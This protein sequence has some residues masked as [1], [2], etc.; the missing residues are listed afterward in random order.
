M[1]FDVVV[2]N[3][4]YLS[5]ED[6]RKANT[7]EFIYYKS[8][9]HS[10]FRQFDKY[11]V[12]IERALSALTPTGAAG[13]LVPN[14]WLT[15]ESASKLRDLLKNYVSEVVDFG[16]ETLFAGRSAYVCMLVLQHNQ[17]SVSYRN[18][19]RQEE[20]EQAPEHKGF[21]MQRAKLLAF[22]CDSWVLPGTVEEDD[23][24]ESIHI[25]SIQLGNL[26]DIRNGIQT[27]KN[28]IFVIKNFSQS[29]G[30]ITFTKN[31]VTWRIES[32]ITRPYVDDSSGVSTFSLTLG[33]ARVVFPYTTAVGQPPAVMSPTDLQTVFPLAWAYLNH[34]KS[35]LEGR[36]VSPPPSAGV[37]YA[38]GRHQALET[39]FIKPKI[40]YSVNQRGD[41]YGF[42][43]AGVAVASGGTA[44]E[45]MILNPK[46]G[47]ALEF[48]LGL[49]N[50][51]PIEFFLRKRGSAFR[52]GYYSRG[53]AVMSKV[54]VPELDLEGNPA[55]IAAHAAIVSNVKAIMAA[56]ALVPTVS[57]RQLIR[58]QR[59]R[60]F[61]SQNLAA[62]FNRL[63]CLDKRMQ[64]VRLPGD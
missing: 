27:S 63:W 49:L 64:K 23:L 39:V 38:Y 36:D 5:T 17:P 45:V 24:L 37:F 55:H 40:I 10:P 25:D 52:G 56:Q 3:P 31:G 4:P 18:I 50:Q 14:K 62:H 57:G 53:S 59:G 42:D 35:E 54:P 28:S 29:G 41:K 8:H 46:R 16:N 47:Y 51:R 30:D 32:A 9:Y 2:G 13:L 60:S 12:F 21:V 15:I 20:Y 1:Q 44:G 33:D 58:L 48:I 11:F 7:P 6:M 26:V 43:T 34:H 19:H 61:L 22:S